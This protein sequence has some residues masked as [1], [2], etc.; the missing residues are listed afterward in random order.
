MEL[1]HQDG[2]GAHPAQPGQ[3]RAGL[4]DPAWEFKACSIVERKP[5]EVKGIKSSLYAWSEM[6][7]HVCPAHGINRVSFLPAK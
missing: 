5:W 2:T 7:V 1:I 4:Q 3:L 6:F